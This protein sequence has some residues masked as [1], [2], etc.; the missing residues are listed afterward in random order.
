PLGAHFTFTPAFASCVYDCMLSPPFGGNVWFKRTFTSTPALLRAMSAFMIVD[1]DKRYIV[2][3]TLVGAP[4][5]AEMSA[6]ARSLG[7]TMIFTALV[8]GGGAPASPFGG[9]AS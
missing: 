4:W 2:M 8:I 9:D 7:S 3:C 5:I 1:D 6:C